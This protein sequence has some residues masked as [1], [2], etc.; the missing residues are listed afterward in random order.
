MELTGRA[1]RVTIVGLTLAA[2]PLF[3]FGSFLLTLVYGHKYDGAAAILKILLGEAILDG[4]TAVLSQAFLAAGVPGTVTIL[5]GCGLLSAIP[6]MY[7]MVPRWGLKAPHLHF[8]FRHSP[9]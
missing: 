5:E 6:L 4:A 2:L 1:A 7:W 3:L 8:Y 9:A